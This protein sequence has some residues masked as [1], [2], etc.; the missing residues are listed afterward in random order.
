MLLALGLLALGLL[1]MFILVKLRK[2][3]TQV[4]P[5]TLAPLVKVE[6]LHVQ[7][8]QMI[9]RG[10]GTVSPK[11]QVEIV[12]QVSGKIVSVNPQ[13]KTGGFIRAN[14]QLLKIDPRD[15]ELAV[16]QAEAA[17]AEAL[18]LLDMEKSE[19]QVARQEWRQL[20][21]NTEPSSP[22]VLR[23]PQIRQ[24][25]A[26]LKSAEAA[27]ATAKLNL[28]RTE[29]SLPV[30][31]RIVSETADLGQYV[32]VG[33]ALGTAYGM[34][35]VEIELPLED[36]ELA[37]FDIPDHTV[38]FNGG[39]PSFK[40][41]IAEV[42]AEF[43]GTEHA[44]AGY[45][46]RTTGQVDKT[47]RQIS[48]VVEVPD[49]FDTSDGRAPLLPGMFVEVFIKGN[50]L[51][52]AVAVPR[53][54]I[55]QGNNVWVV[56]DARLYIQSLQIVR[57]DENF[58]YAISGLEDGAMVVTSSLDTVTNGTEVRIKAGA[59]AQLSHAAQEK[60]QADEAEAK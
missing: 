37:W 36:R 14:G 41:S 54:I 48:V 29:L 16:Q 19:A 26:R 3:P 56:E 44:W 34:K 51:E 13:F 21:P 50:V 38:S 55:R 1:F 24:A 42:K 2:P 12:P 60:I 35:A 25:A 4:K 5:K 32:V 33:K 11:L 40:G 53:D 27:L 6:Q 22:L 20:H 17:V 8:I 9:V 57:K 31:V 28:E 7:D 49:P 43:A 45:V 46:V 52:N 59:G 18:V 10:W 15:Y 30:D 58:A 23:E 47:S 39:N